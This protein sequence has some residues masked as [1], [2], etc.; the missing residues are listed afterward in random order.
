VLNIGIIHAAI[1]AALALVATCFTILLIVGLSC[2]RRTGSL[3]HGGTTPHAPRPEAATRGG[4][5]SSV[6]YVPAVAG[7]AIVAVGSL[8]AAP[9]P[10]ALLPLGLATAGVIIALSGLSGRVTAIDL[11]HDDLVVHYTGRPSFR[12]PWREFASIRPPRWPLGGW[13]IRRADGAA[14]VLMP[15]DLLGF[16][17]LMALA[18]ARS[19]LVFGGRGWARPEAFGLM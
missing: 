19:N 10:R 15:S 6:T 1:W 7:V 2:W 3:R 14:R 4:R 16:E 17:P 9:M 8:A 11:Q 18:V 12:V 13:K 5:T